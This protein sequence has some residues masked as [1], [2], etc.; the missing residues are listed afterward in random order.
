MQNQ[1]LF[2]IT[3]FS[4]ILLLLSTVILLFFRRVYLDSS[5]K[6]PIA[7]T[8]PLIGKISTQAPVIVLILVSTFMVV[9]PISRSGPDRVNLH[10]H[11][12]T[13]GTHVSAIVVAVPDYQFGQDAA[14]DDYSLVPVQPKPC[15]GR[16]R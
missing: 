11:I 7:F 1:I 16:C 4:G 14:S 13:G 2:I 5:T 8:L 9:Y 15:V 3:Q 10:G 12:E 6:E